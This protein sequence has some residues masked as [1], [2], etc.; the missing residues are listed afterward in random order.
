MTA[1]GRDLPVAVAN[2]RLLGTSLVG[3]KAAGRGSDLSGAQAHG[4][5]ASFDHLVGAG[6][7]GGRSVEAQRLRGLL[8]GEFPF[9]YSAAFVLGRV[10]ARQRPAD[11][12]AGGRVRD[13]RAAA[14]SAAARFSRTGLFLAQRDA[15]P[16]CGGSARRCARPTRQWPNDRLGHR[17]FGT[18][19]AEDIRPHILHH[20]RNF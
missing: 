1:M 10:R 16:G 19:R 3:G 11:A 14:R 15:G 7:Y 9:F 18:K 2:F 5:A 13:Q 6:E 8:N 12:R 4:P 17:P 20:L